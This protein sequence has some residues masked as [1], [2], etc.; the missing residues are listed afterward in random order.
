L[1]NILENTIMKKATSQNLHHLLQRA[2]SLFCLLLL[3]VTTGW[4]QRNAKRPDEIIVSLQPGTDTVAFSARHRGQIRQ[5]IPGTHQFLVK[6]PTGVRVEDKLADMTRDAQVRFASPNYVVKN[7]ELSQGSA[8]FIDQG[9]AAFID[10]GSA[11]FID[12][13]S[14]AFIDGLL[15]VNFYGQSSI[16]RMRLTEAHALTRGLGVRVAVIDTGIDFM[17]PRLVGRVVWPNYDF[18]DDDANPQEVAGG[19]GYGHG[20]FVAGLVVSTAPGALIMPLRAFGPDGSGTTFTIAQAIRYAADNGA[21]V[22]NMSFGLYEHDPLI[23]DA[24]NYASSRCYMVAAAGNDNQPALHYPAANWNRTISVTST[25]ANDLKA[26]FANYHSST[27]A[28]APGVALFSCYPGNRWGIW[29]GTSFSTPLVAG[30]AA[31]LLQINS[32]LTTAQ[33]DSAITLS[34]INIDALNPQYAGKLGKRVDC[35]QS[36]QYVINGRQ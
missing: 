5:R 31:L 3:V 11:A 1:R 33:L 26:A 30:Q 25:D 18:V 15:S 23:E 13:G 29:S 6:L 21:R 32:N 35:W 10:Q 12:Q 36:V 4:A 34:G 28:A 19:P 22:I 24:L 2:L 17:H 14:A 27:E 16:S 20:T 8:A 7:A 9:S